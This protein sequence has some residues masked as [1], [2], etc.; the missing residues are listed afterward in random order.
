M[1]HLAFIHLNLFLLQRLWGRV[2]LMKETKKTFPEIPHTLLLKNKIKSLGL[3][4][5]R[6]GACKFIISH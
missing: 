5:A 1:E 2:T 4:P 3:S 6:L